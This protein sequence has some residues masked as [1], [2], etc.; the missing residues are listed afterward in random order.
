ME[1]SQPLNTNLK[2]PNLGSLNLYL[3]GAHLCLTMGNSIKQKN[4]ACYIRIY[5]KEKQRGL[6]D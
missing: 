6:I 5:E 2:D 4:S 1:P 3:Q